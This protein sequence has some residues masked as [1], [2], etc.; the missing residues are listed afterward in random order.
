MF[1]LALYLCFLM[2][3]C[4]F[5]CYCPTWHTKCF[6]FSARVSIIP[7]VCA[8]Y[9]D[10]RIRHLHKVETLKSYYYKCM[11]IINVACRVS[12]LEFFPIEWVTL[13]DCGWSSSKNIRSC[14]SQNLSFAF[15]DPH[16]ICNKGFPLKHSPS[17]HHH[18]DIA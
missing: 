7:S 9:F 14:T 16:I 15:E 2:E 17:Q 13:I 3:M 1:H 11:F 12:V 18:D 8:Q 6:M 5:L 10:D 4:I